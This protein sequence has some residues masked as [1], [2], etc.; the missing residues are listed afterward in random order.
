[1][2]DLSIILPVHDDEATLERCLASLQGQNAAGIDYEVVIID[3]ASTDSTPIIIDKFAATSGMTVRKSTLSHQVGPGPARNIGL[4]LATGRYICYADADDVVSPNLVA[5]CFEVM[6]TTNADILIF[7]F[8]AVANRWEY[9]QRYGNFVA[10]GHEEIARLFADGLSEGR[11]GNG[12]CWNKCYRADFLRQ[13]AVRHPGTRMM[14]DEFFNISAYRHALT[15]ATISDVLYVYFINDESVCHRWCE[16][17]FDIG[18]QVALKYQ[19]LFKDLGV[20]P[21]AARKITANRLVANAAGWASRLWSDN[22]C[23][24][25]TKAC[26]AEFDRIAADADVIAALDDADAPA[27]FEERLQR[28]ALRHCSPRLMAMTAKT[29]AKLRELRK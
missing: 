5:R 28:M 3:D 24:I 7:G 4:E 8:T 23:T 29:Y 9:T 25:D 26:L 15:I 14:S 22:S 19:E 2:A 11:L 18:K 16:Q 1:M 13:N 17:G 6:Q 21:V 10:K 12:F 20:E 27:S